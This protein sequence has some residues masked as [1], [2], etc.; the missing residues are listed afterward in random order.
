MG[1]EF[2]PVPSS[3]YASLHDTIKKNTTNTTKRGG[4]PGPGDLPE[5]G[6]LAASRRFLLDAVRTVRQLQGQNDFA[7]AELVMSR[8]SEVRSMM[9]HTHELPGYGKSVA[10]HIQDFFTG[11]VARGDWPTCDNDLPEFVRYP[12]IHENCLGIIHDIL[13][14][15]LEDGAIIDI[16]EINIK[17][18]SLA[19]I[20][21]TVIRHFHRMCINMIAT[22]EHRGK[23]IQEMYEYLGGAGALAAFYYTCG[24]PIL[25]K[26]INDSF[27]T[28]VVAAYY[29]PAG[30][31]D[32]VKSL[33]TCYYSDYNKNEPHVDIVFRGSSGYN[34]RYV[35]GGMNTFPRWTSTSASTEIACAFTNMGD[36]EPGFNSIVW[37]ID[38]P[39]QLRGLQLSKTSWVITVNGRDESEVLFM[40]GTSYENISIV[41]IS[42][43]DFSAHDWAPTDDELA[44]LT[45]FGII[46]A[47]GTIQRLKDRLAIFASETGI[48][49]VSVE[50]IH[51][52]TRVLRYI[53]GDDD[54][55]LTEFLHSQEAVYVGGG[56]PLNLYTRRKSK[57]RRASRKSKSSRKS[58]R[59][60]KYKRRISKKRK[61]KK[62]KYKK[63]KTKRKYV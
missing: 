15:F 18:T 31:K 11:G 1:P 10:Q 28:G 44:T 55:V 3:K 57:K 2:R 52:D 27:K 40:P 46:E 24:R 13:R 22:D 50:I 47:G 7:G 30:W 5:P 43:D 35:E 16:D 48:D 42:R 33:V 45:K 29:G 54:A 17:I 38:V 32:Y 20:Y 23:N 53:C 51:V 25:Y 12:L 37:A 62:R 41:S 56:R 26:P 6:D 59:K 21:C 61:Y 60:R 19:P 39:P 9:W 36:P 14:G 49:L 8:A 34:H 4:A 63:R 58:K